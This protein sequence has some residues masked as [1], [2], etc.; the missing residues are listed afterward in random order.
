MDGQQT[1]P[2]VDRLRHAVDT[3]LSAELST[4]GSTEVTALLADLEV[5][6]RRL[7]AL[8]QQ[9]VAEA[10]RRGLAYDYAAATPA[11]LLSGLLPITPHEARARVAR[12]R[13]LG[14]RRG[15]T[16]EP[17]DPILPATAAAVRAGQISPGHVQV[18]TECLDAIPARVSVEASGPAEQFLVEAAR[19]EHPGQLRKTA[20]MLLARIDPDGIEPRD[21][22]ID[23]S[24]GFGLRKHQ[25]GT[26]TPT[27][28]FTPELTAMWETVLDSLA[29]PQPGPGG[30]PDTRT[31]AQRRHDAVAETLSRI[32]RSGTLPE[33]G[34]V[35]VT[36]LI[37]TTATDLASGTGVAV[38]SHGTPI[39][40][41][42]LL[43]ISGDAAL[44]AAVCTDTGGIMSYGRQRRLASQG[45]RLALALRDGGCSFPGCD[46]PAAWTEV[47][48]IIAWL[49]LGPTDID[50]MCL[51]CRYHH[52][53]FQALGWE[54][55]MHHGTPLWRPPAWLDPQ[56]K[57]IRNTV[58]HLDDIHF[59]PVA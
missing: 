31:G 35:P 37:R 14:P 2:V 22:D 28:R 30:E 55:S 1:H 12:A 17:L 36:V 56:R 8:D 21:E 33:A 25:D 32:L 41:S 26:S 52:R 15:L 50:N 24:R 59:R 27:G 3:L 9:V 48:H 40:V 5:Q 47:H 39:S 54:V 18:I 11:A 51:L 19:V 53:H 7:E 13:D 58:H 46:R 10:D 49:D 34:G 4:L 6:R 45:Q 38:T 23:R 43:Q 20:A 42:R 44:L 57:P 16:G 29:A